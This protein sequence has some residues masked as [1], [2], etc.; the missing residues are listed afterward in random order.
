MKSLSPLNKIMLLAMGLISLIIFG[1]SVKQSLASLGSTDFHSYWHYGHFVRQG[2]DPYLAYFNHATP[3]V[4]VKYLNGVTVHKLP[5]AK[6]GLADTPANTA[7]L[8]LLLSAFS[9]LSW[10][11]AKVIWMIFN[12]VLTAFIPW[13]VIRLLSAKEA[14]G[15]FQSGLI[16]FLFFILQGTRIANWVGQTTLLVFALMLGSLALAR[17]NWILAGLMLGIALSKYSLAISV[18][19]FLLFKRQYRLLTVSLLTQ[20]GGVLLVSFLGNHSPLLTIEHYLK[21]IAHHTLL[22]GIHLGSL[23]APGSVWALTVTVIGS[24]AFLAF[25]WL[26]RIRFNSTELALNDTLTFSEW[27]ILSALILWSLLVVYHRAYDTLTVIIFITLMI[28][29]L[30]QPASWI[31]SPGQKIALGIFTAIFIAIMSVPS[32]VMGIVLSAD[33]MTEWY[34]WVSYTMTFTLVAAL[35]VNL[36]LLRRLPQDKPG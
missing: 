31:I 19:L 1:H 9:W 5:I 20:L 16:F 15:Y 36:W 18:F 12:L 14:S 23:F 25:L 30:N 34:Q 21:M 2:D 6:A 35:S 32:S 33:M 27:H 24:L 4:P 3:S 13:L 22:P 26:N 17:K 7:P 28:Y 10:E 29:G 11:P 8:V